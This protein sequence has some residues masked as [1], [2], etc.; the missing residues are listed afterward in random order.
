MIPN[1]YIFH[2]KCYIDFV[3]R[4]LKMENNTS[5][6]IIHANTHVLISFLNNSHPRLWVYE[7]IYQCLIFI[8][9]SSFFNNFI[10]FSNYS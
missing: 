6:I 2:F 3:E 4:M 9:D 10:R 1:K 7:I 5:C 8:V